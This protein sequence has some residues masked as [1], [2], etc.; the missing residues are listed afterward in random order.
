MGNSRDILTKLSG[1]LESHVNDSTVIFEQY[2]E[3]PE[4][5]EPRKDIHR[6]RI[7]IYYNA[8]GNVVMVGARKP[9]NGM[10]QIS[11]EISVRRSY[12]GSA[13]SR[14]ELPALDLLDKVVDW[15]KDADIYTITGGAM[16]S[17][18]LDTT[19]G[20]TRR[21]QFVTLTANLSGFRSLRESQID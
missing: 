4:D 1:D 20:F 15:I 5:I 9:D 12:R 3:R 2:H 17:L 18:G 6:A 10:Q 14:G 19:T 7:G 13:A 8:I 11:I 16:H 21:E